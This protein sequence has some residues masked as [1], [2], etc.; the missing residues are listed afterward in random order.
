MPK[1]KTAKKKLSNKVARAL[2]KATAKEKVGPLWEGPESEGSGGGITQSILG[3]FLVCRERFRI[4]YIEGLSPTPSFE[5]QLEYGNMWHLCEE[6]WSRAETKQGRECTGPGCLWEK[7]LNQCE[8]NLCEKY[9]LQREQ[10][11]HWCNVCRVQFPIYVR[12]YM[13]DKDQKQRKPLLPEET[14]KVPYQ[15]PSRAGKTVWLRGK[16]DGVDLFGTKRRPELY[17]WE[18]KTRGDIDEEATDNQLT[19]DL[20]TMFY[21]VSLWERLRIDQSMSAV[22]RPSQSPSKSLL[23]R[24]YGPLRGFFY[25]VIRRPLSG[26]VGSI[27]PYKEKVLK[28]KTVPAETMEHFY[29]RLKVIIE[30]NPEKFFYRWK[31][32]ISEADVERFKREFL[33]PILEQLCNWYDWVGCYPGDVWVHNDHWRHPYGVWN[34]VD[35]GRKSDI[36]EYLLTGSKLGLVQ[37]TL[38]GELE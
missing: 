20:Q 19:F 31:V 9:P 37:T 15:L 29:G 1:K 17:L 18:S 6:A 14:F 4:K 32:R 34:P 16:W 3:A 10:I 26:G 21:V 28:T 27:R 25:N 11:A 5:H 12:H 33:D 22:F 36:D 13:K 35:Q 38:F 30:K 7:P 24:D 2:K 23:G 8:Q